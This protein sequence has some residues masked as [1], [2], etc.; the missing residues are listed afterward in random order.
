MFH[1]YGIIIEY[2]IKLAGKIVSVAVEV[3]DA[4]LEYNLLL[5]CTW[6]YEMIVVF[7]FVFWVLHSPHQGKIIT[8][9]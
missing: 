1:P 3:V 7:F 9:D 6:F 2:P 8:I 5:G 4:P